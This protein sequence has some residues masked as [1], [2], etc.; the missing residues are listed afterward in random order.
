MPQQRIH[1]ATRVRLEKLEKSINAK[2][3]S[4]GLKKMSVPDIIDSIVELHEIERNKVITSTSDDAEIKRLK[5]EE[6]FN[7]ECG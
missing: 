2:R 5:L 1:G 7:S 6:Q 4:L 3:V